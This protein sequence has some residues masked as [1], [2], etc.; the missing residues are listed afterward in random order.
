MPSLFCLFNNKYGARSLLLVIAL[1]WLLR[2]ET[3][4][5]CRRET[6]HEH[7]AWKTEGTTVGC[8][9]L[10]ST[11][12]KLLLLPEHLLLHLC[13]HLLLPEHLL[14]EHLL[15]L[16]CKDILARSSTWYWH[17]HAK[18][19]DACSWETTEGCGILRSC[20]DWS[21]YWLRLLDYRCGLRDL[22][23]LN[24]SLDFHNLRLL[25]WWLNDRRRLRLLFLLDWALYLF[26]RCIDGLSQ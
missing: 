8:C 21:G 17:L 22:N 9:W 7:I 12:C 19:R 3:T 10:D 18:W 2:R 1:R 16:G 23:L 11:S 13:V 5:A 20:L 25:H 4:K 15:L 14:V 24:L 6:T 26:N